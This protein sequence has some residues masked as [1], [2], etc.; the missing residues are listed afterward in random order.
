MNGN[1]LG[2]W[3]QAPQ[4][5]LLEMEKCARSLAR[6]VGYV[7][8]ATVE[9]LFC[10][11]EQKYYF[12]ELNPRLQARHTNISGSWNLLI[13]PANIPRFLGCIANPSGGIAGHWLEPVGSICC[14]SCQL[15]CGL[16]VECAYPGGGSRARNGEILNGLFSISAR[17]HQAHTQSTATFPNQHLI[18]LQTETT[19][20]ATTLRAYVP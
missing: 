8:V 2:A 9:Y 13:P 5:T 6:A 18:T 20:T 14:V 7:G 10:I 4:E 16:L 1:T 19:H 15:A 3:Q 17:R 12:L 11:E